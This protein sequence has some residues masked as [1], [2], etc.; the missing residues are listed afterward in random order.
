MIAGRLGGRELRAPRGRGTR[1]T[2][3]RVREALFSMLGDVTG[4]RVLDLY[5]GT[6]A[7]GIEALSRGAERATFVEASKSA[8][9]ALRDNVSRLDLAEQSRIVPMPVER[10]GKE[11]DAGAPYDLVLCDPPW[12]E[13]GRALAAIGAIVARPGLL[14]SPARVV[15]EHPTGA[16]V[17]LAL[18]LSTERSWG[19]TAVSIFVQE[20]E[21]NAK[22]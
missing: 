12:P 16:P 11:L 8:L 2:S 10:A 13:L 14:G 5:A 20:L 22:L 18:P 1:P 7:L 4:D 9:A 17:A 15:V 3:D 19:D 21:K 6:G